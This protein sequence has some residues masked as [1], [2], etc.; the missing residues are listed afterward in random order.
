MP[1]A[2]LR[3]LALP[4][5]QPEARLHPMDLGGL[6]QRGIV[7]A[8]RHVREWPG[9]EQVG[10]ARNGRGARP[11]RREALPLRSLRAVGR[12]ACELFLVGGAVFHRDRQA[13]WATGQPRCE[14]LG[15]QIVGHVVAQWQ[16]C[17]VAAMGA[18]TPVQQGGRLLL[19]LQVLCVLLADVVDVNEVLPP[20]VLS[21]DLARN[22]CLVRGSIGKL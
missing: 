6:C 9:L 15:Q 21:V 2:R 8:E 17:E 10:H 20:V 16:L 11:L 13:S 22:T 12:E 3:H 19:I 14:L 7:L 1:I 5:N 4:I 18:R